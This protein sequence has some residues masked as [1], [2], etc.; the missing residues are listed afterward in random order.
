MKKVYTYGGLEAQRNLTLPDIRANKAAGI[1]MSQ[2]NATSGEEAAA[3]EAAGIDMLSISSLVIEEVRAGAPITYISAAMGAPH[4]VSP[5]DVM[6]EAMRAVVA[7]ADQLYTIRSMRIVEMLANEGFAVQ[8]HVGLVPR[9]SVTTGGLRAHGKTAEE[10]MSILQ[11]IRRLEDAGAVAVEVE[12]VSTEAMAEISKNTPLITHAI[13][14]GGGGDVI[15]MFCADICGDN[16]NPPRHAKAF[17]DLL[18]KRRA[19]S[20]ER[21]RALSLYNM[22]VKDGA[23]P[24]GPTSISMLPGEHEKFQ[25]ALSKLRPVH[26]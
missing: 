9:K 3:V 23:F 11:D 20:A 12:C 24:D 6:R 22:A 19:L 7:G 10:A 1:K 4:L 15:F 26:E 25:E 14:A 16:P 2:A 8:G 5:D 17:G 13:G 18:A 21:E